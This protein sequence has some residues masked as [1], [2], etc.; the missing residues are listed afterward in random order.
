MQ[1]NYVINN[2][3]EPLPYLIISSK[4]KFIKTDS[5]V[6]GD[7]NKTIITDTFLIYT[8]IITG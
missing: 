6:T 4:N 3:I 5:K 1:H 2:A 8:R 7:I